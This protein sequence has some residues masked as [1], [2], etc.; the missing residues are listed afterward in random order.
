MTIAL[1]IVGLG[2]HLLAFPLARPATV[3]GALPIRTQQGRRN[4]RYG[5][6]VNDG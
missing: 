1:S 6:E 5:T 4:Y 3:V 2:Q